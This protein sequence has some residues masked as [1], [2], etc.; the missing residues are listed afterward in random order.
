MSL[1]KMLEQLETVIK[2]EIKGTN[3][4][5]DESIDSYGLYVDNRNGHHIL[6]SHATQFIAIKGKNSTNTA[7][8]YAENIKRFIT[9][10]L[11]EKRYYQY[12]WADI[13]ND[14]LK[15]WQMSRIN[16]RIESGKTTPSDET[17]HRDASLILEFYFWA[18][19]QGVSTGIDVVTK[20]KSSILVDY[21]DSDFLAHVKK[22][23]KEVI[24][25]SNISVP[26]T[27]TVKPKNRYDLL[28]P[29]QIKEYINSVSD[30]VYKF[31]FLTSLATGLRREETV[32]I[33]YV[34]EG[35]NAHVMQAA[36]MRK[37]KD[38]KFKIYII[39]K[40]NKERGVN[41]SEKD[42]N[43]ISNEYHPLF[44]K[45]RILYNIKYGSSLP[46][47]VLWLTKSGDP[48]TIKMISNA[49]DYAQKVSGIAAHIHLARHWYATTFVIKGLG[50][51]LFGKVAYN[52][53]LDESLRLQLGHSSVRTT[54]QTY[55]NT[56]RFYMNMDT[57]FFSE[58]YGE[59]G[60]IA[61]LLD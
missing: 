7:N 49:F 39:G 34:G 41:I 48:V 57:G 50:D 13:D 24:D 3:L 55:V 27:K 2:V 32:Q 20:K 30:D 9:W 26:R 37:N 61:A 8:A 10:L 40:R 17:I 28:Q 18:N 1:N 35:R 44:I 38:E 52:A 60:L 12:F 23:E 22:K 36:Q 45:R 21:R 25:T 16:K 5:T 15:K 33:P 53:A 54:Y 19:S 43:T 4:A 58:L 31:I 42:W 47:S 29:P 6:L 59:E 51:K 11:K 14:T 46:L 56:A